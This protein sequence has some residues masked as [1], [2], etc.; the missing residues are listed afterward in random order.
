MSQTPRQRAALKA[1]RLAQRAYYIA[2]GGER[3]QAWERFKKAATEKIA[4]DVEAMNGR[5]VA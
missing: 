1:W 5:K 2:R 3:R 4:A